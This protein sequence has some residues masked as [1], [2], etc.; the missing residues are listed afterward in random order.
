MSAGNPNIYFDSLTLG[1]KISVR[2]GVMD[3]YVSLQEVKYFQVLLFVF[4]FYFGVVFLGGCSSFF[5]FF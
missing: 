1:F 5:L 3:S 2:K 4:V